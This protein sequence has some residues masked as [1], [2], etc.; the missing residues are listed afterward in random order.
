MT[1]FEIIFEDLME[2]L[3]NNARKL[4]FDI[5]PWTIIFDDSRAWSLYTYG[6]NI[7]QP[8]Y[9]FGAYRNY[10][11]GGIRGGICHNG[12]DAHDTYEL[13]E[14]FA[15]YLSKIEDLYNSGYEDEPS[16][17]QPTGVLL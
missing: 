1:Q 9:K 12:D 11:G 8:V 6:S 4:G 7:D 3:S 15:E 17:E 10:L 5:K 14:L 13:G 16:W 2:E